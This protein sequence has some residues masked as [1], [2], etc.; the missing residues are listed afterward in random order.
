MLWVSLFCSH[1][2]Y[3]QAPMAAPSGDERNVVEGSNALALDLYRQLKTTEGNLF[4]SPASI[5][6]ALAIAYAGARGET[7]SEMARTLHFDLEPER[8]HAAMSLVLRKMRDGQGS[9]QLYESN[10]LWLQKDLAF[11]DEFLKLTQHNYGDALKR[12]DFVGDLEAARVA[13]NRTV[14]KQTDGKIEDLLPSGSLSSDTRLILTNAIYF[15]GAWSVPFELKK[16]KSENFLI[17]QK[18]HVLVP[19]MHLDGDNTHFKY[20]ETGSFR[21]IE[22]PYRGIP[23]ALDYGRVIQEGALSMI[24]FLPKG[25]QSLAL[26]EQSLTD[27]NLS[28]WLSGLHGEYAEIFLTLPKFKATLEFDLGNVLKSLGARQMFSGTADFSG[29]TA[30]A[31]LAV[32]AIRHKAY[33]TVEEKGTEAASGTATIMVPVSDPPPPRPAPIQFRVDH[34]FVFLIR[35]NRSGSILFLGRV[36]DPSKE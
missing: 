12:V 32:S 24:I 23:V 29:M 15:K 27:S 35:D 33:V 22:I 16:T 30:E 10:A 20:L 36:S 31:K 11:H 28:Q 3:A 25:N 19:F 21:A 14:E 9:Y 6:T 34:P 5:S 26:F 8:L 17:T 7:A 13:I 18:R 1:P 4:F 2:I